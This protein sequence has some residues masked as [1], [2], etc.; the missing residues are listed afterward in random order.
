MIYKCQIKNNIGE[1]FFI[2]TTKNVSTKNEAVSDTLFA[3]AM[4]KGI[5]TGTYRYKQFFDYWKN[6]VECEPIE[7]IG[8]KSKQLTFSFEERLCEALEHLENGHI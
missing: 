4:K 8:P 5:R 7:S 2:H 3:L 6:R 1:I